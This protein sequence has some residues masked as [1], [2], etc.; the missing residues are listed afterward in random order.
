MSSIIFNKEKLFERAKKRNYKLFTI[1]SMRKKSFHKI[2]PKYFGLQ[3][4][5]D[6]QNIG[7]ESLISTIKR[8]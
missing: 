2:Q 5:H 7:K 3:P 1:Y 4:R 8:T 6:I